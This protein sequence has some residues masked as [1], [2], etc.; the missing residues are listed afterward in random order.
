MA[1]NKLNDIIQDSL[2]HI[3][4][5]ID[6]NT[7]IGD[8]IPTNNGTLIIPIS[9]VSMGFVS[10]GVDYFGKNAPQG[11]SNSSFGGGGG[12]GVTVAPL[13]FLVIN[14]AG[15]VTML[16]IG[17]SAAPHDKIESVANL[18]EKSPDIIQRFKDVFG[19]KK[20]ETPTDI[21]PE[22]P[23]DNKPEA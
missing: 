2:S 14:A 12:T 4:E 7:I 10:G 21:M 11:G 8:P 5:L 15:E 16:N 18:I 19:K 1:D 23:E 6:V 22:M 20:D 17:A 13:G 9:K 3:K